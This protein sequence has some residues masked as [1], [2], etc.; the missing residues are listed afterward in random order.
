M[1]LNH[2]DPPIRLIKITRSPS[3]EHIW[4]L[5]KTFPDKAAIWTQI[6]P[7]ID[8]FSVITR[9]S[10]NFTTHGQHLWLNNFYTHKN[11]YFNNFTTYIWRFYTQLWHSYQPGHYQSNDLYIVSYNLHNFHCIIPY[12]KF[13]VMVAL[14][15]SFLDQNM[16]KKVAVFDRTVMIC[17]TIKFKFVRRWNIRTAFLIS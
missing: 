14:W 13:V 8:K 5:N 6:I 7:N 15:W 10:M 4:L 9:F 1:H 2:T 11:L 16:N 3:L 12:F 17:F